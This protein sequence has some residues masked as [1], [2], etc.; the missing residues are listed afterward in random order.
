MAET[1]PDRADAIERATGVSWEAWMEHFQRVGAREKSHPEI[2]KLALPLI[3]DN[4]KNP[5]WWAQGIAIAFE[6]QVGMR[7]PGESSAGTFQMSVTRTLV[8][9][10]DEVLASWVSRVQHRTHQG[11]HLSDERTSRTDKRSYW[12]ATLEDAGKLDVAA[13]AKDG[14]KTLLTVQ[15]LNLPSADHIDGWRAYWKTELSGM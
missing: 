2:V 5:D 9:E 12:R 11:Y 13:A 8:G 10:R 14:G 1:R 3:P 7:V 6:H 4:V 15:H